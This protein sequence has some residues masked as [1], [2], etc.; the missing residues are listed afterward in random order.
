MKNVY[1][2]C[3]AHIDPVWLWQWQEG[4]AEAISTFRVAADFCEEY[5]GFVFNHNEAVLYRWIEKYEPSLFT[6][7]QKL[8]RLGKWHIMGGWYLQPDCNLPSGESFVRQI[9][10]GRNYFKEKFDVTPEVAVNFDPFGHSRGLVQILK[11]TGYTAYLFMRPDGMEHGSFQ[12]RGFDGSEILAHKLYGGYNSAK[13][14]ADAKIRDYI[15]KYPERENGL[16][17]WGVGNHGGGASRIDLER[18][19]E[20]RVALKDC[21]VIHSTP[22]EYF[23]TENLA[24]VSTI[25]NS[26]RPSFVGCY[27]SMVKIKQQHR[28]LENLIYMGEKMLTHAHMCHGMAYPNAEITTALECLMFCQFHDILP[29]TM[30]KPAEDDS[31]QML[32]HGC[33]VM[34]RVLAKAFFYLAANQKKALEGEIPILVYNPHPYPIKAVVECEFQLPQQNW[35]E[36]ETTLAQV[37]QGDKFIATQNEKEVSNIAL[38]WRKHIAF[39]ADLTPYSMNRFDCKLVVVPD[40]KM[41]P[42]DEN[43]NHIIFSCGEKTVKIN[44]S[45]GLLDEYSVNG[46]NYIK[47]NCGKLLVMRDDED[48]WGSNFICYNEVI[49]E[50]ELLSSGQTNEFIGYKDEKLPAVRVIEN[51]EVRLCVQALFRY[52]NSFS[53]VTY[54]IYKEIT[55]IDID[56]TLFTSD[57]NIMIKYAL[58][59]TLCGDFIGQTAFGTEK[60]STEIESTF[61]KWCAIKSEARAVAIINDGIYGGDYDAGE[62]RLSLLH[63]P[64]YSALS[65]G[66]PITTH[67][68]FLSHIDMGER[69]FSF[70]LLAGNDV[71]GD[72]D[73]VSLAYNEKPYVLSF[74]P[75]EK[76]L[77]K[78]IS[79]AEISN[80]KIIISTFKC[81][82]RGGATVLRLYNSSDKIQVT[83]IKGVLLLS[84]NEISFTPFEVKTFKVVSG[85][86]IETDMLENPY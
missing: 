24:D 4:A 6:R 10:S 56:I 45:T 60:L 70:K 62:L 73:A 33:D 61:Q 54:K 79:F 85:K 15:E 32:S 59:T 21:N 51:G 75:G 40:Y 16:V 26:L 71:V 8:V 28:K 14:A 12:W 84:E 9:M 46:E 49:G 69:S 36:N 5:N 25:S 86:L 74:F 50:F 58:P 31:H 53:I 66:R 77:G 83:Q 13:G 11:K 52:K 57:V 39:V 43:D 23:K 44:K 2:I 68:R 29:G 67:D 78:A 55:D 48:P 47:E 35:N 72:I 20:L 37:Y 80:K 3:N 34:N 1:L 64:A 63:T 38:D 42:V 41:P 18:L 30:I 65:I 27:T 17:T 76:N 22:E 19:E 81:A 7:I 82:E